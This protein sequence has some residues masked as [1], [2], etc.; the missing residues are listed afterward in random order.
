MVL[1]CFECPATQT[2]GIVERCGKFNRVA[3]PGC[4]VVLPCIGDSVVANISLRIQQLDVAVETKT[5]D[6]VFVRIVVSVQYQVINGQ[7]Y[8]AYYAL[9]EPERR[10]GGGARLPALVSVPAPVRARVL[11]LVP[12]PLFPSVHPSIETS[13]DLHPHPPSAPLRQ[14]T[15]YIF[16]VVR[17]TVPKLP[18]DGVF[19]S[20][21][22]IAQD[23]RTELAKAMDD[24]GYAILQTLVTDI[25]PEQRVKD[26]MN[27][28]NAAQRLR[29]AAYEKAEA[30]KVSVVKAAE[31]DAEAKFLAGQGIARQRQAIVNGLRESVVLFQGEVADINS[32]DVLEMMLM[33]QARRVWGDDDDDEFPPPSSSSPSLTRHSLSLAHLSHPPPHARTHALTTRTHSASPPSS[34]QYFDMLKDV[35]TTPSNSTVFMPHGPGAVADSAAQIRNGFAQAAAGMRK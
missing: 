20:K 34:A 25:D 19:T 7:H 32:K 30:D 9:S 21:T 23:V 28:I 13:L 27:Q 31:A 17:S 24:Y 5:S 6:D 15:A 1:G 3:K 26:A 22:E 35:G 33:T 29:K 16:D 14:I 12:Q 8:N 4:N 2:V 10:G 11:A 18:L